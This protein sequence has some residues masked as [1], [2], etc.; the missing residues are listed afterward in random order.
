MEQ[1]KKLLEPYKIKS[2]IERGQKYDPF[3]VNGSDIVY[4]GEW[5]NGEPHGVGELLF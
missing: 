3:L 4:D 5:M 2:K 1:K